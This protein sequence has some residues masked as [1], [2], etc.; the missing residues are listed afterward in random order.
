MHRK[1]QVMMGLG[2]VL[3]GAGL[4]ATPS[5]AEQEPAPTVTMTDQLKF[6]PATVKIKTGEQVHWKNTSV[7]VHTVT[8]DPEQAMQAANVSLPEGAEPF[9]SGNMQS[10]DTFSH[11]F[12]EPGKY[13]YFC[14]PHE[15]A[16]MVGT[17]IVE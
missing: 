6:A 17:V 2:L 12:T 1:K 3:L 15:M 13:V 5:A 9:D 8:A 7:M 14:K 4:A 16:G 11:R 10:G